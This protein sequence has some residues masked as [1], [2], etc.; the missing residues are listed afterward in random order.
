MDAALTREAQRSVPWNSYP[1]FCVCSHN[2][3]E[4]RQSLSRIGLCIEQY[5]LQRTS[6]L[7]MIQPGHASCLQTIER[8]LFHDIATNTLAG[9][10][11]STTTPIGV[12]L[13]RH[14]TVTVGS[15]TSAQSLTA[16]LTGVPYVAV[17]HSSKDAIDF[18]THLLD[19]DHRDR[20]SQ[21]TAR[22]SLRVQEQ[23]KEE[24]AYQSSS[25]YQ[26]KADA[27]SSWLV[28]ATLTHRGSL[29]TTQ[30][31]HRLRMGLGTIQTLSLASSGHLRSSCLLKDSVARS[32]EAY[33]ETDQPI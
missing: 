16:S 3:I 23:Q 22:S 29:V 28:I 21:T 25:T 26:V 9:L 14:S 27:W 2:I 8:F 11:V 19:Q 31:S 4:L 7:V 20:L 33:F 15:R 24:K 5:G 13:A 12:D 1:G 10:D 30:E 18:I 6:I 32:I 17:C